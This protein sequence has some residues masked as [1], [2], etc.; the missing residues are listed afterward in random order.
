MIRFEITL[1]KRKIKKNGKYPLKLKVTDYNVVRFIS[2]NSEYTEGQFEDIFKKNPNGK[3]MVH[4]SAAEN[5]LKRAIE[6]EKFIKPFSFEKFKELLFKKENRKSGLLLIDELYDEVIKRKNEIGAYKTAVS[7]KTSKNTLLRFK[8]GL[9]VHDITPEFL[10]KF[11]KWYV[12]NH[13]GNLNS[14]V[15][16]LLRPLRAILNEL[17]SK[18]KLPEG[19]IYPFGKYNYTIP[20][21]KKAKITLKKEEIISLLEYSD[22]Q[23]EDEKYAR[24]LWALQF[25][26]NGINLK[27][28]IKL[29]WSDKIGDCFVIRREKTK[30]T[31]RGNPQLIRIPVTPKMQIILNRIGKKDSPYVLGFINE[32]SRELT[33]LNKKAK[34]GKFVNKHLTELGQRLNLSI[35]LT[36][37]VSRDAY[38]TSLKKNNV[39]IEKIAEMLGH[40]S[41][42]VTRNYLDSFDLEEVHHINNLLP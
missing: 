32:N 3:L 39:S 38:A 25:Y 6:I 36:T 7:Y 17:K 15:S 14:S 20:E 11:E 8:S 40:S 9:K 10:M 29:R 42:A 4:R 22:F 16:I 23:S 31:T 37:K 30:N 27:D 34:V 18:G 12:N 35:Q 5:V 13:G 26:C 28:L 33:I 24:D 21:V 1:D 19:Y 41:T 2:L